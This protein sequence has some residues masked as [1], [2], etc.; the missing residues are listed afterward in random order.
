MFVY[1]NG[2]V[3]NRPEVFIS[4]APSKFDANGKLTDATTAEHLGKMLVALS[5]AARKLKG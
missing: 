5:D 1:L 4:A 2:Q 3:L